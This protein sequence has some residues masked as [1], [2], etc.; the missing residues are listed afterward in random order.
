M[1]FEEL[2]GKQEEWFEDI[3]EKRDFVCWKVVE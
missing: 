3:D 1:T 2:F